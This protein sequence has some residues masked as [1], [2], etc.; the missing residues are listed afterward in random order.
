MSKPIRIA[1]RK[2]PLA[3]WQ[4]EL[5]Y[6]ATLA[7]MLGAGIAVAQPG[8][9][10]TSEGHRLMLRGTP[11]LLLFVVMLSAGGMMTVAAEQIAGVLNPHLSSLLGQPE[12][13]ALDCNATIGEFVLN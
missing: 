9:V 1:T 10:S 6:L 4:A 8:I 7:I 2:S 13:V 12:P 5:F 3:L 11:V